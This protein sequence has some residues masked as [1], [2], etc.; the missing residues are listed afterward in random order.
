MYHL[1][2]LRPSPST[3]HEK[4]EGGGTDTW[5]EGT[6]AQSLWVSVYFSVE[7][8]AWGGPCHVCV[9]GPAEPRRLSGG[10]GGELAQGPP[11]ALEGRPTGLAFS[12][13]GMRSASPGCAHVT[14][15]KRAPP[16]SRA[17][18][19]SA[20]TSWDQR[21]AEPPLRRHSPYSSICLLEVVLPVRSRAML[22]TP[23]VCWPLL[24]SAFSPNGILSHDY[25]PGLGG[26]GQGPP[27]LF[28]R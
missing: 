7:A 27:L 5:L 28:Y 2:S 9:S 17:C 3:V 16:G 19:C 22:M 14:G 18:L 13:G 8:G 12:P 26:G 21:A 20:E 15:G 1:M 24:L 25:A 6:S 4:M 11:K 10:P 23:G